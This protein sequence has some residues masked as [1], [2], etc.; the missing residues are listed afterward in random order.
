M[1]GVYHKTQQKQKINKLDHH[2]NK[3]HIPGHFKNGRTKFALSF[4]AH[5]RQAFENG[6]KADYRADNKDVRPILGENRGGE[7]HSRID[8]AIHDRG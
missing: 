3:A 5:M 4:R 8:H 2:F 7:V 6:N 1:N